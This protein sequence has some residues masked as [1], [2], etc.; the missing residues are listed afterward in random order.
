MV[1]EGVVEIVD[2]CVESGERWSDGTEAEWL[3]SELV[4]VK[5]S[6]VR[7]DD[8]FSKLIT[9]TPTLVDPTHVREGPNNPK[10]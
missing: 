10:T 8:I 2:G 7:V 5:C 3:W 6:S 9:C 4:G 1:M